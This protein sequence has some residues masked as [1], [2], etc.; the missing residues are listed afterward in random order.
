MRPY[1]FQKELNYAS[2]HRP[3]DQAWLAACSRADHERLLVG[4]HAVVA[5]ARPALRREDRPERPDVPA[6]QERLA[7]PRSPPRHAARLQYVVRKPN[8]EPGDTV[9][10]TPAIP[11]PDSLSR[12]ALRWHLSGAGGAF[13]IYRS[14]R[15]RGFSAKT[16]TLGFLSESL[17]RC[18]C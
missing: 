14:K 6:G 13:L 16:I 8:T 3:H 7:V 1:G 17:I 5:T 9:A 11:S 18:V 4:Q 12:E 10:G 2:H 15:I